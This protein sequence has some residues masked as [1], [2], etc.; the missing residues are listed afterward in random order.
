MRSQFAITVPLIAL[1]LLATAKYVEIESA[2]EIEEPADPRVNDVLVREAHAR[3]S[4]IEARHQRRFE[5]ALDPAGTEAELQRRANVAF[6]NN[7]QRE[8]AALGFEFFVRD[9]PIERRR[10]PAVEA[11][12]CAS[13]HHRLGTGGAGGLVDN[14]FGGRSPPAL[15]GAVLI[16]RLAAEI[17]TELRADAAAGRVLN[18]KGISFGTADAPKGIKPD[19]VL[20]P[21]GRGKWTTVNEAVSAMGSQALGVDLSPAEKAA[22]RAWIA[23]LPA[24]GFEPPDASRMP[25]LFERSHRGRLRFE[26]LGCASCHVPEMPLDDGTIVRAYSDFKLHDLG[27]AEGG[28]GRI[29]MTAPLWGVSG[30][31][32]WLSDGSALASLEDAI[33]AHG[34]DAMKAVDSYAALDVV[35]RGEVKLFLLSL[36]PR[37]K[38]QVAGQ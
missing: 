27:A 34:G 8:L 11:N 5:E 36:S 38:L 35:R 37:P 3:V 23:T 20:R 9:R 2:H 6:A 26:S 29:I 30:T 28:D 16:E 21:F 15:G 17:T 31:A 14:Y 25:D 24:P 4:E 7:D 33:L 32:P 19:L 10:K 18:A 12:R 1:A 13:C 22:I